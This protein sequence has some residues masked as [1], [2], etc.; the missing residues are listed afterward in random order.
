MG[1]CQAGGS[2]SR[3][4]SE[5]STH[6]RDLQAAEFSV[7]FRAERGHGPSFKQLGDGLGWTLPRSVLGFVVVLLVANEWLA[8]TGKVPWM[9]RPGPAAR[10]RGIALPTARRPTAAASAPS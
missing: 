9:L 10:Q 5:R 2:W 3:A 8:R 6:Y 7:A 1:T 4:V